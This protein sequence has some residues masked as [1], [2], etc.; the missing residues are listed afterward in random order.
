MQ[1]YVFALYKMAFYFL[2]IF[3]SVFYLIFVFELFSP[4]QLQWPFPPMEVIKLQHPTKSSL[5]R[6]DDGLISEKSKAD[7][8]LGSM[9]SKHTTRFTRKKRVKKLTAL[10]TFWPILAL[11]ALYYYIY[12]TLFSAHC[13]CY[14][15]IDTTS[16]ACGIYLSTD[17]CLWCNALMLFTASP[18]ITQHLEIRRI[19]ATHLNAS[20]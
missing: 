14:I 16:S 3:L 13:L 12:W 20:L 8:Y 6:S 1:K 18:L 9:E 4:G 7:V 11:E 17:L 5:W 2:I 10:F 19:L 15:H